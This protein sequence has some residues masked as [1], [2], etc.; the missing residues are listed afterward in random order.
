MRRANTANGMI[1]AMRL[2]PVVVG[3]A[4]TVLP[5]FCT[6]L[7]ST[8]ESLSPRSMPG[9]QLVAHAIGVRAA[10]VI[11]LQQHLVAAAHAH[12][13]MA[14]LVEARVGVGAHEQHGQQR[15]QRELRDAKFRFTSFEFRVS[16]FKVIKLSAVGYRP[17][18]K[19][20]PTDNASH[21]VIVVILSGASACF[22]PVLSGR[23]MR[24]RRTAMQHP[25][26]R[27]VIP[28][29]R[30]QSECNLPPRT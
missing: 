1:H 30:L 12:Q 23:R 22:R 10:D 27:F 15:D 9:R 20:F 3:A 6:K 5:Y 28:T 14:E 24:S 11:A 8:S 21:Q 4:S 7:C 19:T 25:T 18:A 17:S 16:S 26:C 13:L 29:V 2:K